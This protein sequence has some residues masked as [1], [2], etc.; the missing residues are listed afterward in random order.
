MMEAWLEPS[1]IISGLGVFVTTIVGY[2]AWLNYRLLVT[3]DKAIVKITLGESRRIPGEILADIKIE[4][5]SVSTWTDIQFEIVQPGE[6]K[7]ASMKGVQLKSMSSASTYESYPQA[8]D[9]L[10]K[11]GS[12][13]LRGHIAAAGSLPRVVM[14][15][16]RGPADEAS[17]EVFIERDKLRTGQRLKARITLI[18]ND[19]KQRKQVVTINRNVPPLQNI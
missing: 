19:A 18:S 1:V 5:H 8:F 16:F 14:G 12:I 6:I 11:T 9:A 4:N 15:R 2:I 7:I 3:G 17:F 13:N 10:K